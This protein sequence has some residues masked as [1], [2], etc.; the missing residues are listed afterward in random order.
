MAFLVCYS[1]SSPQDHC[2]ETAICLDQKFYELIFRECLKARSYYPNLSLVASLRY[3]SPLVVIP[4]TDITRL[5]DEVDALQ[6]H[7]YNHPQFS[8]LI[9]VCAK[10]QSRCCN[11][12]F[13]GNMYP[14]L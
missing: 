4:S 5:L 14:E 3:K 11:L 7:G 10:A 9:E 12:S 8:E 2:Q 1:T 13:S 6:K